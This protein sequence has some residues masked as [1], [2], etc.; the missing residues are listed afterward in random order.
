MLTFVRAPGAGWRT[1]ALDSRSLGILWPVRMRDEQRIWDPRFQQ[2]RPACGARMEGPL[3]RL[4]LEDSPA[5][6]ALPLPLWIL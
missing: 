1:A 3:P 2:K 5:S 4:L 6:T